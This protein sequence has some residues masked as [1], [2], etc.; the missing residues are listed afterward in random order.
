MNNEL[1]YLKIFVLF[2]ST[3]ENFPMNSN[4]FDQHLS[5]L[6]HTE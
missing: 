5:H 2:S 6:T 1:I 3:L 4:T